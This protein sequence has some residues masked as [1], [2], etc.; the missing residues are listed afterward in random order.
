MKAITH[1]CLLSAALLACAVS[2]AADQPASLKET[3]KDHFLVGT[4]VNR[5][6]VTG[7]AGFRR[8]VELSTKDVALLKQHFNQIVAENDIKWQMIHPREGQDGYEFGP[9]DA[10]VSFGPNS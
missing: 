3:F 7:G 9:T 5:N 10:L 6:M 4:A 2:A 1:I 8:S